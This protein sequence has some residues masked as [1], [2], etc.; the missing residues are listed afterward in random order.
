METR[1][2]EISKCPRCGS[3][4]VRADILS[5]LFYTQLNDMALAEF[6]CITCHH[7]WV[8]NTPFYIEFDGFTIG[9]FWI[10]WGE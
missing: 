9:K 3:E 1:C 7:R 10:S 4:G 6:E 5:K 8:R 2:I